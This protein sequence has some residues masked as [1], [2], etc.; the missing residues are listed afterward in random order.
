MREIQEAMTTYSEVCKILAIDL[1]NRQAPK[2]VLQARRG[3]EQVGV[4]GRQGLQGVRDIV[5]LD[6]NA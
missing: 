1:G 2:E 6:G 3:Y 5:E 4:Q